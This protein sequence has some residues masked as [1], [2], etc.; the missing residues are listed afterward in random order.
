LAERKVAI[1]EKRIAL[2]EKKQQLEEA[3]FQ[4]EKEERIKI[5]KLEVDERSHKMLLEK[6]F[7]EINSILVRHLI[8]K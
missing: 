4:V 8:E 5:L 6:Q 1:E 2:E 7:A 3:K